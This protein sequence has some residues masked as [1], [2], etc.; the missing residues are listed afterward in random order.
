M[1]A[2]AHHL[3]HFSQHSPIVWYG[4]CSGK[5]PQTQGAYGNVYLARKRTTNDLFAIKMMKKSEMLRKNMV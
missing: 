5:H 2:L 3:L 1:H 4:Y